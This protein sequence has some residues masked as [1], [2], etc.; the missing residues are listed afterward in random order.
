MDWGSRNPVL[1]A[2]AFIVVVA[3]GKATTSTCI[4]LPLMALSRI[5]SAAT[6]GSR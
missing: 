5:S 3:L 2:V 6:A 4:S 1:A